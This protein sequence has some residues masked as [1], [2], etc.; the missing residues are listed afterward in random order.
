[1]SRLL[2]SLC[3][4][5]VAATFIS[6]C[7]ASNHDATAPQGMAT[8]PAD[9]SQIVSNAPGHAAWLANHRPKNAPP[10]P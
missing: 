8:T 6:G 5:G 3:L 7:N 9:V 10:T 2:I 1:M 4:L